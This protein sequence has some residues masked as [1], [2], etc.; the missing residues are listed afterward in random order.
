M[1]QKSFFDLD[2]IVLGIGV[3]TAVLKFSGK[4]ASQHFMKAQYLLDM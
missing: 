3:I 2:V 1:G 4:S